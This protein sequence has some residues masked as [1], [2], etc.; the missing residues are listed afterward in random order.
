MVDSTRRRR[1]FR[2]PVRTITGI[3]GILLGT[4]SIISIIQRWTGVEIVIQIASDALSLY[5]VMMSNFKWA[6]F[7][8]WTP[9]E[10]PWGWEVS[11]PMWG[12]DLLAIYIFFIFSNYRAIS[13]VTNYHATSVSL[14]T[15][16]PENPSSI[17]NR[18]ITFK[19]HIKILTQ[20]PLVYFRFLVI[21]LYT[22]PKRFSTSLKDEV[23][24]FIDFFSAMKYLL[25]NVL[26]FISPLFITVG[27][28]I[29]NAMQITPQG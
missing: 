15:E 26:A 27:F 22:S 23:Y 3:L 10:L 21:F 20:A 1:A 9:I 12:M 6:I 28:F 4:A 25:G 24:E 18:T 17:A 11:M 29:W 2:L 14:N 5:R 13:V 7:D 8:W 19:Q 16:I